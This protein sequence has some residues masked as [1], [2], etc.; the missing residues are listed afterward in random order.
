MTDLKK[1]GF[2]VKGKTAKISAVN[3]NKKEPS[4]IIKKVQG[5]ILIIERAGRL[6][7]ETV[8]KIENCLK[9]D[10]S[11]ILV[12]VTD[13]DQGMNRFAERYPSLAKLINL[14]V[15]IK[16]YSGEELVSYAIKYAYDNEYSI[17][18]MGRLALQTRIE[19]MIAND[20]APTMNDAQ[21]IID[22]AIDHANQKNFK[23]FMDV[24]LRKRYDNEDMIVLREEDFL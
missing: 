7:K 10:V 9:T 19:Q 5:G 22:E 2:A 14:R 13:T 3:L 8:A 4:E 1:Q 15:D 17:E 18:T 16:D 6:R 12:F 24:L 20:D 11:S 21:N 23:H